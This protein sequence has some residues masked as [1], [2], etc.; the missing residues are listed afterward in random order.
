MISVAFQLGM[1]IGEDNQFI[2]LLEMGLSIGL[3]WLGANRLHN[4]KCGKWRSE[5]G[6]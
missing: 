1:T 3:V 5:S 2:R 4:S 6:K